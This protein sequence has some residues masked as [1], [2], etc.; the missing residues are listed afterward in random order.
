MH[1]RRLRHR[2]MGC[3]TAWTAVLMIARNSVKTPKIFHRSRNQSLIPISRS[4]Q[5]LP[6][7]FELPT[8]WAR[9]DFRFIFF[10]KFR[11]SLFRLYIATFE[12]LSLKVLSNCGSQ[13]FKLAKNLRETPYSRLGELTCIAKTCSLTR[14]EFN[15]QK[16]TVVIGS[17]QS[18]K[19]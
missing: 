3:V 9:A 1:R 16:N 17:S 4:R 6:P 10:R 8:S 19:H 12:R 11:F 18:I 13:G 2:L 5:V 7:G 15:F 14:A